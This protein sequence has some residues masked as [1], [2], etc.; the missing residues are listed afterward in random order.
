MKIDTYMIQKLLT[1]GCPFW[2]SSAAVYVVSYFSFIAFLV[3]YYP[4]NFFPTY[5][6]SCQMTRLD[7]EHEKRPMVNNSAVQVSGILERHYL[8]CPFFCLCNYWWPP[9][10]F[11]TI[12]PNLD[13]VSACST[14]ITSSEMVDHCWMIMVIIKYF[15]LL[16]VLLCYDLYTFRPKSAI[17]A[18]LS[19]KLLHFNSKFLIF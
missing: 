6:F 11:L 9:V 7:V 5:Y 10:H 1:F 12:F 8:S 18:I 15:Q 4:L 14:F 3:D 2:V 19:F 17:N 13:Y 16:V